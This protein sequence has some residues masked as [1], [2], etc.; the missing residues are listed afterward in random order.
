MGKKAKTGYVLFVQEQRPNVKAANPGLSFGA[1]AKK[2]GQQWKGLTDAQRQAYSD[3]AKT[4][5]RPKAT[6]RK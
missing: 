2:L 4:G 6:G 1:I 5:A 3:R